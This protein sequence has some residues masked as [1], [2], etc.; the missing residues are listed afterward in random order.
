M[1]RQIQ[2]FDKISEK[3]KFSI[4]LTIPDKVILE[5]YKEFIAEDPQLIYEYEIKN[6]DAEF[7]KSY[8]S[9]EFDFNKNDYFLSCSAS[10]KMKD[11]TIIKIIKE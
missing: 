1:T 2:V 7:Y 9:I 5:H 6:K 10:W 8:L 4:N 11:L 3:Y